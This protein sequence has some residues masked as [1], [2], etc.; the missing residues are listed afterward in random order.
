MDVEQL[1]INEAA[2]EEN[3][4]FTTIYESEA[5]SLQWWIYPFQYMLVEFEAS[6]KG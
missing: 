5:N 1:M 2:A 4:Q 6:R 3:F